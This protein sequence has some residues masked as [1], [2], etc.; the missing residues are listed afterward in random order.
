GRGAPA[1]RR[2]RACGPPRRIRE[3][4]GRGRSGQRLVDRAPEVVEVDGLEEV[5]HGPERERPLGALDVVLLRH[6]EQSHLH[7]G[8]PYAPDRVET[9]GL[10]QAEADDYGFGA[11]ALELG[12]RLV[13]V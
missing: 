11:L 4:G 12:Q 9:V 10:T 1:G 13:E 2:R 5:V 7:V 6:D 3:S 8:L